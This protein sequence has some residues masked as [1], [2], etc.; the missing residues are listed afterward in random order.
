MDTSGPAQLTSE[1]TSRAHHEAELLLAISNHLT[2]SSTLF[3]GVCGIIDIAKME[4]DAEIGSLFFND[5]KT[6]ELFFF[7]GEG[8]GGRIIRI[9]NTS[10]IAGHVFKSGQPEIVHDPYSDPRFNRS[11]DHE[12]GFLTRSIMCVPVRSARGEIIGVAELLNKRSEKFAP[13]EMALFARMVL[14]G[15]LALK[16]AHFPERRDEARAIKAYFSEPLKRNNEDSTAAQRCKDAEE[17][18]RGRR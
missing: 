18:V 10:G 6:N 13:A 15:V 2:Q 3:E 5:P 17:K 7:L 9:P 1:K 12:T 11:V 14:I 8:D 16:G 4:I